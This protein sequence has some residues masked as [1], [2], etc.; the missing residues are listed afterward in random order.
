MR[1]ANQDQ[2]DLLAG[3][4]ARRLLAMLEE[5]RLGRSEHELVLMSGHEIT[6]LNIMTALGLAD[7]K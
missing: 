1:N 5:K 4:M 6:M 7:P 3:P 2:V